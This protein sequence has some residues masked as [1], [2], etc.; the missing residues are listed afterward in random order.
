MDLLE[1]I[2]TRSSATRLVEPAPSRPELQRILD[3]GARAPDHGR[4][5]PWR[6]VV[7][8]G[9][10]RGALGEAMAAVFREKNVD[11]TAEQLQSER[12]KAQRAPVIIAVASHAARGHKV[13]AVEQ[14]L[15]TAACVQNMLLTAHALGFGCMWKTGAAAYH[16][17]CKQ[18][19]GLEA[20]D[21]IV[22]LVYLG[23]AQARGPV[24][25][26]VLEGRVTWRLT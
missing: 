4:L 17:I 25:P 14:S 7:L 18:A 15:A 24:R 26:P 5:G 23:T 11:A 6:F 16:P 21:E 3:S 2:D 9:S 20:E 10:A 1:A 8:E 13:P 12:N 19:L 22:A